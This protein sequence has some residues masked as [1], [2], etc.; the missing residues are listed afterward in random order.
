MSSIQNEVDAKPKDIIEIDVSSEEESDSEKESNNDEEDDDG[1]DDDECLDDDESSEDADEDNSNHESNDEDDDD[2]DESE[3][4]ADYKQELL[5]K[6]LNKNRPIIIIGKQVIGK[7]VNNYASVLNFFKKVTDEQHA[8]QVARDHEQLAQDIE[9]RKQINNLKQQNKKGPGRPRK[10]IPPSDSP[11]QLSNGESNANS[12]EGASNE[13]GPEGRSSWFATDYIHDILA[14]V[15]KQQFNFRRVVQQ[16]QLRFPRLATE[17]VARFESLK[18][19]TIQSWYELD[20]GLYRLK[21][22]YQEKLDQRNGK[23]KSGGGRNSMFFGLEDIEEEVKDQLTKLFNSGN[24]VLSLLNIKCIIKTMVVERKPEYF[25]QP[26]CCTFSLSA[27]WRW[28]TNVMGWS[29]KVVTTSANLPA[30]WL[31]R[32]FFFNK[33]LCSIMAKYG[34]YIPD[35]LIINADQTGIKLMEM[36]NRTFAPKANKAAGIKPKVASHSQNDKRQ[37]TVTIASS[38]AG[39]L[40][41]LQLIFQGK[42]KT[43]L[44]GIREDT[45]KQM[46][47]N[48][49]LLNY[50]SNHWSNQELMQKYVNEIIIP[51][52]I[53]Y[54]EGKDI[55]IEFQR[56]ILII[57]CWPVHISKEFRQFMQQTEQRKR[58]HIV[59]VPP[60]CTSVLQ[61]ADVAIQKPFKDK[62]RKLHTNDYLKHLRV[63]LRKNLDI[64]TSSKFSKLSNLKPRFAQWIF[65]TW[66]FFNTDPRCKEIILKGWD[67]CHK[68]IYDFKSLDNQQSC[69]LDDSISPGIF[70]CDLSEA[71]KE[72]DV[73][74]LSDESIDK[75]ID[76][77]DQE[78]L[79]E[80]QELEPEEK[81]ELSA[82]NEAYEK[83]RKNLPKNNKKRKSYKL[84]LDYPQPVRRPLRRKIRW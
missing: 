58:I 64:T 1:S 55:P 52:M 81:K 35:E 8:K 76:N 17:K 32:G 11:M 10:I 73:N 7:Q 49:F 60:N 27:V 75:L 65:S 39:D 80:P 53:K 57:D 30:N 33:Q 2:D 63:L 72:P 51:R 21:E 67:R 50:S 36:N 70:G 26:G 37:I 46:L 22:K 44:K 14:E 61:V 42:T 62:I 77:T 84:N 68:S 5:D 41:P 24:A 71:E 79:E 45:K 29:Y 18:W 66:E 25:S 56:A 83:A 31:E 16:L 20:K 48:G 40:L 19:P 15:N 34:R 54:Y 6:A 12:N 69:L 43:C 23:R 38:L 4:A 13:N 78:L 74:A 9:E 3:D 47:D 59:Y 82:I 28:L